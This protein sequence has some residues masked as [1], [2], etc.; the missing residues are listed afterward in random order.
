MGPGGAGVLSDGDSGSPFSPKAPVPEAALSPN[1]QLSL[2][3]SIAGMSGDGS[4]YIIVT[5][6][7]ILLA[8]PGADIIQFDGQGMHHV[9]YEETESYRIT[10]LFVN[11]C[12]TMV[13]ALVNAPA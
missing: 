8:L 13:N 4:Q 12:E 11:H 10:E 9:A 7:P 3:S 1:R 2:F 6:S 5:H